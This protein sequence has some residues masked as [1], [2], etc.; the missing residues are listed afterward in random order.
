MRH[1]AHH[2]FFGRWRPCRDEDGG[3]DPCDDNIFDNRTVVDGIGPRWSIKNELMYSN[4]PKND[5]YDGAL[6]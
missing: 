3:G 1:C 2:F 4:T 5:G 6:A